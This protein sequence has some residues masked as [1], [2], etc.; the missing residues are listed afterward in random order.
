MKRTMYEAAR[1]T[2]KRNVVSSS[3]AG[4]ANTT[5]VSRFLMVYSGYFYAFTHRLRHYSSLHTVTKQKNTS[6]GKGEASDQSLSCS[7]SC[8]VAARH[9][10]AVDSVGLRQVSGGRISSAGLKA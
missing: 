4:G 10:S 1:H 7:E 6:P 9:K 2:P 3:L 5:A 8:G